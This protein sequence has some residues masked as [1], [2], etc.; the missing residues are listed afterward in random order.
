MPTNII[1]WMNFAVLVAATFLFLLF[2][3]RSVSPAGRELIEGSGSYARAGSDRV[4]AIFFELVIAINYV[5]YSIFQINLP[6]PSNF[7]WFWWISAL[8][9]VLIGIPSF[10]LMIIGMHDAGEEAIRPKKDHKLYAGIYTKIRHPQAAGEVWLFM[11]IGFL[12]NSPF[13]VVYSLVYF[14][15]FI[16]MCLAEEQDLLLRYGKPYADYCRKTGAFI[17]KSKTGRG[18]A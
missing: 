18:N 12:L 14:P 5:V 3:V 4:I 10:S 13:L 15:V 17:P 9:A 8:I 1:A 11:V 16:L 7:P 2:Y 6:L